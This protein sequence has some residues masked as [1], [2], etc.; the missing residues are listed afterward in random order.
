MK[1]NS[2]FAYNNFGEKVQSL[3]R[4]NCLKQKFLQIPL[5]KNQSFKFD[6]KLMNQL[7]FLW[8]GL[9]NSDL[10]GPESC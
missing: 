3:V 8:I 1:E 6:D 7:M 9:A 10:N 4:S 2:S 5:R